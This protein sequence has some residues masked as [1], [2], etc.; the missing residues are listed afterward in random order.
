VAEVVQDQESVKEI[1][2]ETQEGDENAGIELPF[3]EDNDGES[4]DLAPRHPAMLSYVSRI[5]LAIRPT[6]LSIKSGLSY[7]SHQYEGSTDEE[8]VKGTF[9]TLCNPFVAL[10]LRRIPCVSDC[11]SMF[12]FRR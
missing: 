1:G 4:S 3:A 12:L 9:T 2:V 5:T 6:A 7:L 8:V 11:P 10:L